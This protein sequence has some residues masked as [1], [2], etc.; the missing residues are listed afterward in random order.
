M[1]ANYEKILIQLSKEGYYGISM[2]LSVIIYFV[3]DRN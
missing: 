3:N 1:T 2:L